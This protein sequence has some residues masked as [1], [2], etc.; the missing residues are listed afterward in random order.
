MVFTPSR[1][2]QYC[3]VCCSISPVASQ[4][5][6]LYSSPTSTTFVRSFV[7]SFVGS[8]VRPTDRPNDNTLLCCFVACGL[9]ACVVGTRSDRIESSHRSGLG[10]QW[11]TIHRERNFFCKG[12]GCARCEWWHD[13]GASGKTREALELLGLCHR[14]HRIGPRT[15]R[16]PVGGI[17]FK[18]HKCAHVN[19]RRI[20]TFCCRE[21]KTSQKCWLSS[22]LCSH[23]CELCLCPFLCSVD[24]VRPRKSV[25]VCRPHD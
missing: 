11:T 25:A 1:S 21:I 20:Q 10:R 18:V 5:R 4:S 24:D 12:D 8:L 13:L 7:C 16:P 9:S 19:R 22:F 2:T 6:T 17:A 15:G 23:S 3:R 14:G